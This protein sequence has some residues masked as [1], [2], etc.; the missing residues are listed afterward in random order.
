MHIL[1]CL[2]MCPILGDYVYHYLQVTAHKQSGYRQ[3]G[4]DIGVQFHPKHQRQ[5]S[6]GT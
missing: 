6:G 1:F 4:N 2:C 3:A 5:K